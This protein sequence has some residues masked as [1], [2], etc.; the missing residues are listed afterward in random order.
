MKSKSIVSLFQTVKLLV[1]DF[2][3]LYYFLRILEILDC[4][5]MKNVEFQGKTSDITYYADI[6]LAMT[7]R[8]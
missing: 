2:H 4:Q 3:C 6:M 1:L 8:M 7:T 5:S